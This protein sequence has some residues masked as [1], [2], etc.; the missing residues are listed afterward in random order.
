MEKG[1]LCLIKAFSEL[2]IALNIVGSGPLESLM[3]DLPSNINYG[4]A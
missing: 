4:C 1:V 2:D 3:V